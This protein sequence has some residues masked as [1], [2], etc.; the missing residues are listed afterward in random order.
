M[1]EDDLFD[2]EALGA[3]FKATRYAIILLAATTLKNFKEYTVTL[4]STLEG[5][6]YTCY[7]L[8]RLSKVAAYLDLP[9]DRSKQ[10]KKIYEDLEKEGEVK[11][12]VKQHKTYV[13]LTE[14][15]KKESLNRLEELRKLRDYRMR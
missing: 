5:C 3:Y 8:Y 14:K 4:Y 11:F 2:K 13:C 10:A 9:Y 7:N 1:S 6:D 15:G 12:F